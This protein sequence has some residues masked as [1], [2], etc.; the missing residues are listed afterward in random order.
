MTDEANLRQ[1][2]ADE[3][4][5]KLTELGLPTILDRFRNDELWESTG[6]ELAPLILAAIHRI[7]THTTITKENQ[8]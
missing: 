6:E 5:Q 1:R 2:I 7:I 4:D 3:V 8:S